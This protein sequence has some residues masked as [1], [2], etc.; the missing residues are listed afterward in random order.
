MI[1]GTVALRIA[2]AL[3]SVILSKAKDLKVQFIQLC[4]TYHV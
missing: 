4:Y 3:M 2:I 1:R